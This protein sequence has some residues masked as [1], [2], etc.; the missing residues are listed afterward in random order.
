MQRL[1]RYI[2]PYMWYIG[3]AIVVKLAAAVLELLIP[4]FMEII[5]DDVVPTGEVGPILIF[6][7]LMFLSAVGCIAGN[8]IANRMSAV[9]SGKITK[10]LRHDL[11]E[12]LEGSTGRT[13][14]HNRT[15]DQNLHKSNQHST[16]QVLFSRCHLYLFSFPSLDQ[17]LC[18]VTGASRRTY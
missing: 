12:K 16:G 17:R 14:P 18:R 10:K 3:L 8:I 7:G 1:W 2:A 13:V 9:S 15:H 11:F 4:Y 6:G 5:L